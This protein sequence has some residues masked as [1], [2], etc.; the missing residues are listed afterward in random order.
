MGMLIVVPIGYVKKQN[1]NRWR[2]VMSSLKVME[3]R[4]V[5][6]VQISKCKGSCPFFSKKN[7][8]SCANPKAPNNGDIITP[9]YESGFPDE[10][11]L[12]IPNAC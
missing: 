3:V 5:G 6:R 7:G 9:A 1:L 12:N 2:T 8:N 10:C 4:L 11:P